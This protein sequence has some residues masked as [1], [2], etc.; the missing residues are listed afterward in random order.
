MVYNIGMV[1]AV[2]IHSQ[3]VTLKQTLFL[4]KNIR[5][6][7]SL[8]VACIFCSCGSAPGTYSV[9]GVPILTVSSGG[10]GGNV[11]RPVGPPPG[12]LFGLNPA[13]YNRY[14][15]GYPSSSRPIRQIDTYGERMGSHRE[16]RQ[17]TNTQNWEQYR[18]AYGY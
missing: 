9:A 2:L 5:L 16:L 13:E 15:G 12:H 8:L 1:S 4:M 17:T 11:R 3:S 7:L 18:Q 14:N 10:E 6:L